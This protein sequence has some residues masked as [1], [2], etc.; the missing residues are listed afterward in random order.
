MLE[1]L[2]LRN[3][4][5]FWVA[6]FLNSLVAGILRFAFVW[7]ILEITDWSAAIGL[8]GIAVGLP[9]LFVSL[10]AGVLSDRMDRRVLVMRVGL[11]GG[12]ALGITAALT[13][14]GVMNVP[15]AMLMAVLSGAAV[16]ISVPAYQAMVPQLVPP[17]RLMTGV[18]LQNMGQQVSTILGAVVGGGTI[19]LLGIGAGF[20]LWAVLLALSSLC[21]LPVALPAA[22][23]AG[24]AG[25][26]SAPSA[27]SLTGLLSDIAGG[28]RFA[29]ANE[30]LRSLMIAGLF[31]GVGMGAYGILVPDVAR[32]QL[33]KGAFE[34]S[35]M[36]AVL[37][38]GMLTSSLVLASRRE[39]RAK[40]KLFLLA[41]S[42][43]GPGLIVIGLSRHY[44]ATTVCMLFYGMFA[45]ILL[46]SQR[47][48]LQE[49]TPNAM[50][51]RVMS[52]TALTFSGMLPFSALII[53]LMRGRFSSGEILAAFGVVMA[54]GSLVIVLRARELRA[55]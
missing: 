2:A 37:S 43:F 48:L 24:A 32:N 3:Y 55:A 16:A 47:T 33:G 39:L 11:A 29:A 4:R 46:A 52:M 18:A 51:G 27:R 21:M 10:P 34:T 12:V 28:I 5:Y 41:M 38:V 25:A 30:P 20:A 36:F 53:A 19:A 9:A 15:L 26:A 54:A 22:L 40:G 14:W 50:M 13:W 17:A 44:L 31:M 23:P 35:L 7:L 1:V 42:P 49:H 8:I 6:Q 45:G